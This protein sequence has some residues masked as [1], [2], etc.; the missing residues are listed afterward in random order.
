M[1]VKA[2]TVLTGAALMM[3]NL[4]AQAQIMKC[5]GKDGRIEFASSCPPGTKQMDTGVSNKPAPASTPA[6][7]EKG[8][9]KGGTGSLADREA[10]FRKRQTEQKE[11]ATKAEQTAQE[12]ADRKRACESAQSNIQALRAK[13]RMFR[14]DPKTGE[15]II[16]DDADYARELPVAERQAAENCK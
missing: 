10:D 7:D 14:I 3:L 16:Y 6:R 8:T 9:S 1:K 13:Q 12:N 2:F 4:G 5:I 11:S 15:R